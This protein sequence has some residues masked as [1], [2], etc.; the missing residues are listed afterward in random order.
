MQIRVPEY[1]FIVAQIDGTTNFVHNIGISSVSIA[2]LKNGIPEIG[3]VYYLYL[4]RMFEAKAG[5]GAY[6]NSQRI[7]VSDRT[8]ENSILGIAMIVYNV[9]STIREAKKKK[10][11]CRAATPQ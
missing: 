11:H 9:L 4:N 6:L 5:N 8:D 1:M 3:V 2:L 10:S 7:N